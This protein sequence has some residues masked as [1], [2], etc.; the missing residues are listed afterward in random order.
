MDAALQVAFALMGLHLPKA[1]T[2]LYL[3]LAVLAWS[4]RSAR[5]PLT[6]ELKRSSL[7]LLLFGLAYG[8]L[9]VAFGFWR[10]AGTELLDLVSVIVLPAL[11]LVLGVRLAAVRSWQRMGWLW[12]AY[13][14]GGLL[15]VWVVLAHGRLGDGD[16]HALFARRF[17]SVIAVPWGSSPTVNV[18]SIEQNAVL[19]LS[20]FVPGLFLMRQSGQRQLGLVMAVGG[21]LGLVAVVAFHGRIGLLVAALGA[22]PVAAAT[23]PA[24]GP[25]R[26]RLDR[27]VAAA[28]ALG[29][30]AL[31]G[32]F[33]HVHPLLNRIADRLHDERFDRFGGFLHAASGFPWGGNRIHFNYFD[34][35]QGAMASFDAAHGEMLHNVA[36]DIYARVGFVPMLALLL[37][38]L[39]LLW[40]GGRH[41]IAALRRSAPADRAGALV[42]AGL[43]LTLTVQW[44]F[45]PLL[46][47][48][49]LF[50]YL[51]FLLLG[52]L[53]APSQKLA[54]SI[55]STP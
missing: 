40:R 21:V 42:A 47:A 52:Y 8:A 43:L 38:M 48:D 49:G 35:H 26:R 36:F 53:A 15:Y 45:Q 39:P 17:E 10:L 12:L 37:A 33:W 7:L 32:A 30:L 24:Q 25:W 5:A 29:L 54:S 9:S 19:A 44:L 13:G 34:S 31:L 51:G 46:Y 22:V 3:T 11:C 50:F 14:L 23:W 41:L 2:L 6:P 28:A 55:P 18:R 27:M 1:F 16:L 4:T 20:W